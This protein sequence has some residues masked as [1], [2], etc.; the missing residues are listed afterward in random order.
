MGISRRFDWNFCR[1]AKIGHEFSERRTR[2]ESN[3]KCFGERRRVSDSAH[4]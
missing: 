2:F 1:P 3:K 4:T